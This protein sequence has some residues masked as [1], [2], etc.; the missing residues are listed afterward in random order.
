MQVRNRIIKTNVDDVG[1]HLQNLI[2]WLNFHHIVLAQVNY[3]L[4]ASHD[5]GGI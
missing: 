3:K 2:I 4:D 1:H 5:L